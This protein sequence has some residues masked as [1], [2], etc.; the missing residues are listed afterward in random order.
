MAPERIG[1]LT[2]PTV[3]GRSSGCSMIEFST[4][5]DSIAWRNRDSVMAIWPSGATA[6]PASMTLAMIAPV[7]TCPSEKA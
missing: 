6:R 4:F 7:E 5:S 3:S 2:K 1:R